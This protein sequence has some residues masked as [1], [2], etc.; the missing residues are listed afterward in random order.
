LAQAALAQDSVGDFTAKASCSP[1]G[2]SPPSLFACLHGGMRGVVT[3]PPRCI[4]SI[5]VSGVSVTDPSVT[6]WPT[7]SLKF[8]ALVGTRNTCALIFR[9]SQ[10]SVWTA[11]QL[12]AGS[13]PRARP[14]RV[15]DA[16]ERVTEVPRWQMRIWLHP[17]FREAQFL[18]WNSL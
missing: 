6:T 17:T 10:L 5:V 8:P 1:I 14:V 18:R 2:P 13:V 12:T 15:N 3:D 9:E 11:P 16:I 4:P 7:N